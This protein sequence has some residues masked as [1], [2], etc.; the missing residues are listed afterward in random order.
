MKNDKKSTALYVCPSYDSRMVISVL[1]KSLDLDV[2]IT[3]YE[4]NILDEIN[5]LPEI[6]IVVLDHV[7]SIEHLEWCNQLKSDARTKHAPIIA[8][9]ANENISQDQLAKLEIDFYVR[10]PV[11]INWFQEL[12][13]S[14]ITN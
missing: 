4:A 7:Y 8:V 9:I 3:T 6:N 1:L 11:D 14:C 10:T 5:S 13:T 12:V 2:V